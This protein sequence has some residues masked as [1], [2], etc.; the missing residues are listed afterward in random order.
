MAEVVGLLEAQNRINVLR[1][2]SASP[3]YSHIGL[4]TALPP[5]TADCAGIEITEAGYARFQVTN[6]M[7]PTFWSNP[8]NRKIFNTQTV[9]FGPAVAEWTSARAFAVFEDDSS[10][11]ALACGHL[12][13]GMGT[14]IGHWLKFP[15][16]R[17]IFS[18]NADAHRKGKSLADMQLKLFQGQSYSLPGNSVWI[19][20]GTK[21]PDPLT[22]DFGELKAAVNPAYIRQEY[23]CNATSWSDPTTVDRQ[24]TN[25]QEVEFPDAG[26]NWEVI[27]SFGIFTESDATEPWYMGELPGD[28][29]VRRG[30]NIILPVD[31]IVV[32]E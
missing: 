2:L 23:P 11:L 16:G 5:E 3:L 30:D 1:G 21:K 15:P 27:K 12:D 4:L 29:I 17:L 6:L 18:I 20:L 22:S 28:A 9:L 10:T 19:A 13:A 14:P 24:I 25:Q 7:A 26:D 31:A 32:K 8:S